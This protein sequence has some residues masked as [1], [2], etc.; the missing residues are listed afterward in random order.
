MKPL[1]I[2]GI[3]PAYIGIITFL[4]ILALAL[5]QTN[6]LQ[7]TKSPALHTAAL[8]VSAIF[9]LI[10]ILLFFGALLHAKIV[11]NIKT[12]HLVTNGVY[13]FVRNP[14]YSGMLCCCT[15]LLITTTNWAFLPLPFLYWG[16]MTIMVKATE[17][18]V[19]EE[20]FGNEYLSYKKR[21]NRCIPW[22]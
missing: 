21:V 1:T 15:G 11:Q 19:L 9:I 3:G 20:H 10:G 7:A 12:N 4:T 16:L 17:E 2:T 13:R 8:I 14:M 22:F 18:K 5:N 6:L